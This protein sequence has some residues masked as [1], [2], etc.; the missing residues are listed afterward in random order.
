MD[1]REARR[2][3]FSLMFVD[4]SAFTNDKTNISFFLAYYHSHSTIS[5]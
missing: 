3:L 4:T 5:R 2:L 1:Y